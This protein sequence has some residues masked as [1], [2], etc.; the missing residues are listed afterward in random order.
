MKGFTFWGKLQYCITN[1]WSKVVQHKLAFPTMPS[2]VTFEKK[3][4][5]FKKWGLEMSL[6]LIKHAVLEYFSKDK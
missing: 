5:K 1:Y 6:F 3:A 2:F 4:T